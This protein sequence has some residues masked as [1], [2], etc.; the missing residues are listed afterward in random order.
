MRTPLPIAQ[1]ETVLSEHVGTEGV[2]DMK[3]RH[4]RRS[5]KVKEEREKL[6][7]E[8]FSMGNDRACQ[9]AGMG[10]SSPLISCSPE[11]KDSKSP[12][13][14][15]EAKGPPPKK[16]KMD[17]HHK[18]DEEVEAAAGLLETTQ[19]FQIELVCSA[20]I[21]EDVLTKI[22]TH[23]AGRNDLV[24]GRRR[25]RGGGKGESHQA[26]ARRRDEAG[27]VRASA[28]SLIIPL[29]QLDAAPSLH[30][31]NLPPVPVTNDQASDVP[32]VAPPTSALQC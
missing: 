22:K 4:V 14:D 11:H 31:R 26:A 6:L 15:L 16:M 9:Q 5:S 30:R 7:N 23:H 21:G 17:D 25:R 24:R 20:D 32:L 1:L 8:M 12:T 27:V 19:V 18:R 3:V 10:S 2:I 13:K 29:A 28:S